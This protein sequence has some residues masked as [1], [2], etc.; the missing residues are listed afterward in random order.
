MVE[1]VYIYIL[2]IHTVC[3]RL[4][5]LADIWIDVVSAQLRG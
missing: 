3:L 5:L 1:Y 2:Y 4:T